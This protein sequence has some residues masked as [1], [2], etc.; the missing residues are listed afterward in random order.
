MKA[1]QTES[2]YRS[3]DVCIIAESPR[4]FTAENM[5]TTFLGQHRVTYHLLQV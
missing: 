4:W 1:R 2:E 5:L 3:S